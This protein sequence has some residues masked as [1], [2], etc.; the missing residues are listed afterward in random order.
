M[1]FEEFSLGL[2]CILHLDKYTAFEALL[3]SYAKI[4]LSLAMRHCTTLVLVL[5]I[6]P[7]LSHCIMLLPFVKKS[8]TFVLFS[9]RIPIGKISFS[10]H[11][12][13]F[14]TLF[15]PSI[16]TPFQVTVFDWQRLDKA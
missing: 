15:H 10:V 7:Q 5:S 14:M 4:Q 3:S 11:Y 8:H 9:S 16:Q 12:S 1:I 13:K 6:Q 2:S